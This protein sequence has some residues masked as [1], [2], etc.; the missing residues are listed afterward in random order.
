MFS[1]SAVNGSL[2][3]LGTVPA[4]AGANFI[5]V[6][7]RFVYVPNELAGTISQYSIGAGGL[8]TPIAADVPSG[9]GS[10]SITVDALAKNAYVANRTGDSVSHFTIDALGALALAD[11]LTLPAGT[12]PTS[13][14]IDPSRLFAYISDRGSNGNPQTT[15]TQCS[16]AADG[17][18][19][20]LTPPTAPAGTAPAAIITSR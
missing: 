1:V 13:V 9:G 4:G 6:S 11:T 8:L 3:P 18:L 16:I 10:W 15:V 5:V 2:T 14:A 19:T 12:E 20:L 7:G 17:T